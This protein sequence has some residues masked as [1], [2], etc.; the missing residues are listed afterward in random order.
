MDTCGTPPHR[1]VVNSEAMSFANA[2]QTCFEIGGTLASPANTHSAHCMAIHVRSMLTGM[3]REAWL[4]VRV[5]DGQTVHEATGFELSYDVFSE[6]EQPING[7]CVAMNFMDT[8]HWTQ[9]DCSKM[10]PS[11]CWQGKHVF[12]CVFVPGG[13][14]TDQMVRWRTC[15]QKVACSNL[16][17]SGH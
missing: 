16:S 5:E 6:G 2:E 4:G 11:V 13:S 3:Q 1:V 17:L 12:M 9:D 8:G 14:C 15:E 7:W 10:K